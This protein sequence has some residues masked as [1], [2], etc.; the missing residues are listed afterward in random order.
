MSRSWTTRE[1][2]RPPPTGTRT[3]PAEAS[4][5]RPPSIQG[6]H[7]GREVRARAM[8]RAAHRCLRRSIGTAS[9]DVDPSHKLGHVGQRFEGH[10]TR[11]V[12]NAELEPVP[13]CGERSRGAR[14][15][16][17][18][19]GRWGEIE[20]W[21][22][23]QACR[24]GQIRGPPAC[25]RQSATPVEGVDTP[26]GQVVGH[27]FFLNRACGRSSSR[28]AQECAF[29]PIAP[30]THAVAFAREAR[31]GWEEI[32]LR[33]RLR[34]RSSSAT[35]AAERRTSCISRGPKLRVMSA[36]R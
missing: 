35:S 13:L 15:R 2:C 16:R 18:R 17:W 4:R 12:V 21:A 26:F 28:P 25:E 33:P 24:V 20:D 22:V 5:L 29:P 10:L 23:R 7:P 6:P 9:S 31:H 14:H 30:R 32:P 1:R 11:F 34:M 8:E 19:E 3:L 36:S 27:W